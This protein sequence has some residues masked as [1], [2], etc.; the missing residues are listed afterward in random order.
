MGRSLEADCAGAW[1]SGTVLV[2]ARPGTDAVANG[3][4]HAPY[5][6]AP[7]AHAPYAQTPYA[8]APYAQAPYAQAPYEH[9]PHAQTP[10]A[11][12][13]HTL[14]V[15]AGVPSLDDVTNNNLLLVVVVVTVVVD[16]VTSLIVSRIAPK[17]INSTSIS[18]HA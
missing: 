13:M 12:P 10:Y 7:Y 2:G 5:A 3:N 8:Q 18:G 1:G 9:A 16:V 14:G 17:E 6:Q 4:A 15:V 11:H